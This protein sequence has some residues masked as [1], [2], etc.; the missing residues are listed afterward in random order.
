MGGYRQV[1]ITRNTIDGNGNQTTDTKEVM[2]FDTS[3]PEWSKNR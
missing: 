3:R 2:N 1:P